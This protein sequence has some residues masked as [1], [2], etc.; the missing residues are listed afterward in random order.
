MAN[1]LRKWV[2]ERYSLLWN[3]HGDKPL[4]YKEVQDTLAIDDKNTIS[5]FLS[6][7]R[8]AGW[9]DIE[10]DKKDSRKRI[11]ILKSPNKVIGEISNHVIEGHK[12]RIER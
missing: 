6:E 9:V 10:L 7:L 3:R 4:T 5:V 12:N 2:M 11:Y 1:T 8:K